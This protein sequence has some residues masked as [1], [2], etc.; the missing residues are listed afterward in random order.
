[1]HTFLC[2]EIIENCQQ[3]IE[4]YIDSEQSL[5]IDEDEPD[6]ETIIYEE[7]SE[8]EEDVSPEVT[9]ESSQSESI[10]SSPMKKPKRMISLEDKKKAVD[11]WKS[12]KT[13][14]LSLTT[15]SNRYR[16]VTSLAQL[17]KFEHQLETSGTRNEMLREIWTYTYQEFIKAKENNLIIH[18]SDLKRW[19]I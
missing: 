1:M 10:P 18:D 14:R 5:E 16:F 17:Y 15:V 8:S 12:G 13:K 3:S 2:V 4:Y 19:A 9:G 7:S 6:N 11:F